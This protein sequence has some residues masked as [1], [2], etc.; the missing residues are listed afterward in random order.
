MVSQIIA[1]LLKHNTHADLHVI[2][3]RRTDRCRL[4]DRLSVC[5]RWS[6]VVP[7]KNG[8]HFWSPFILVCI[9]PM[10]IPHYPSLVVRDPGLLCFHCCCGSALILAKAAFAA[11]KPPESS[12]GHQP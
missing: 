11:G 4:D 9:S 8:F 1:V 10:F 5:L 7:S 2:R 3:Q 12:L 6:V